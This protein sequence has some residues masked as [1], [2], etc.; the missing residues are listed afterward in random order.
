MMMTATAW[1]IAI[2]IIIYVFGIWA[3]CMYA[4]FVESEDLCLFSVLW[5][6]LLLLEIAVVTA[7]LLSDAWC[8][9]IKKIPELDESGRKAV[10]VMRW[11]I[12]WTVRAVMFPFILVFCPYTVGKWISRKLDDRKR[13]RKSK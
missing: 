13:K 11:S 2:G 1:Y 9:C 10:N 4:G 6:L 7:A 12:K 5:P 8:W 3:T